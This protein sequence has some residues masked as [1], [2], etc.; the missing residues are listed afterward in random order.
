MRRKKSNPNKPTK[1]NKPNKPNNPNK[2]TNPNTFRIL[3]IQNERIAATKY[4]SAD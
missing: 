2:P 3:N 1:R 4:T